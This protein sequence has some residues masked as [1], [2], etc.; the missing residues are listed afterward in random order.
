MN[1]KHNSIMPI[2]FDIE[3]GHW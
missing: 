3:K 2:S 1:E